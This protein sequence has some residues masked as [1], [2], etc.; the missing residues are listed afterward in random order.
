M[1]QNHQRRP[2][3]QL[4]PCEPT[5]SASNL[6]ATGSSTANDYLTVKEASVMLRVSKSYLDKLRCSGG[7][8]EFVRVGIRKIL[9]RRC[10]LESWI[11]QHRFESTSQYPA[12]K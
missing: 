12:A 3:V 8:P 4:R 11:R 1:Y 9:Y 5:Q 10:D 6:R 2:V 7:G